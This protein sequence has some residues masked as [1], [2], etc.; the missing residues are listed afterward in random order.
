MAEGSS[1]RPKPFIG[2][3]HFV[4]ARHAGDRRCRR[5][6]SLEQGPLSSDSARAVLLLLQIAH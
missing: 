2:R 4:Y 3:L 6:A 5:A 1:K